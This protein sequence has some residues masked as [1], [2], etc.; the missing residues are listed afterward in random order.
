M[1]VP[2]N[3]KAIEKKWR[4]AVDEKLADMS[5]ETG[6]LKV[7]RQINAVQ[8]QKEK[9]YFADDIYWDYGYDAVHI[10]EMF[11]KPTEADAMWD[12]GGIDGAYRF[13]TRFWRLVMENK[14]RAT[15]PTKELQWLC[16]S[17]IYAVTERI[18]KKRLNTAIAV[19]ME[20][21]KKM[22]EMAGKC[23]IDQET[24]KTAVILLAPFAPYLSEELWQ[25]LGQ[26]NS[27]FA[28]SWPKADERVMDEAL[29]DIPVQVNGKVKGTV[30][31]PANISEKDAKELG[32]KMLSEE[33]RKNIVKEIYIPKRIISY[34]KNRD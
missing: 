24:L 32:K 27:V 2:Y 20:S 25:Q 16:N 29:I 14:D 28:Q 15:V 4:E 3:Y 7:V 13:L 5:N 6:V 10:Y 33:Q 12:D 30:R 11:V 17:M 18:N 22:Q 26:E 9:V 19:L 21:T 23:G 34:K 31:V 8:P 1:A